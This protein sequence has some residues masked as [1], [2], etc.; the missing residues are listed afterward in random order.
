MSINLPGPSVKPHAQTNSITGGKI[1]AKPDEQS[2][3][4]N[5][6]NAFKTGIISAKESE[7]MQK[8]TQH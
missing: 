4:I 7:M 6:M 5:E 8:R 1:K 2:A 3:P